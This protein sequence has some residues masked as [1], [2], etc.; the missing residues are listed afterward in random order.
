MLRN[1][2]RRNATSM[3]MKVASVF[4]VGCMLLALTGCGEQESA[5]TSEVATEATTQA[6]TTAPTAEA[7]TEATTATPKPT[8]TTTA[9]TTEATT[10]ATTTTSK[11]TETTTAS[12]TE[13]TT[14]ALAVTVPDVS[15]VPQDAQAQVEE[16]TPE[17][18]END[19]EPQDPEQ[20]VD[21]GYWHEDPEPD[22][23]ARISTEQRLAQVWTP[24]EGEGDRDPQ[25][26]NQPV[27]DGYWHED[28]SSVT[29][30]DLQAAAESDLA[31][32]SSYLSKNGWSI[33]DTSVT[34][35]TD[36]QYGIFVHFGNGA[37][38]ESWR[39]VKAETPDGRGIAVGW[40]QSYGGSPFDISTNY[41][42]YTNGPYGA[43][44]FSLD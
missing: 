10:E 22:D 16:W 33:I 25:E 35:A 39:M 38:G 21:D 4:V 32:F 27:D 36:T 30:A 24:E 2:S 18:G 7:T 11:P 12:T 9:S 15:D 31:V 13:A 34:R 37:G 23:S 29:A 3:M 8:E 41:D 42:D 40:Y 14:E 26:P 44:D 5:A 17:E 20:P 1:K 43:T 6:V 19:R 28:T